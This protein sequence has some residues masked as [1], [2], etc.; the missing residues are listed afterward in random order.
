MPGLPG[1]FGGAAQHVLIPEDP[2]LFFR[3]GH[4][5]RWVSFAAAAQ[6]LVS[7]GDIPPRG[8]D[9][10]PVDSVL[11]LLRLGSEAAPSTFHGLPASRD[12]DILVIDRPPTGAPALGLLAWAAAT[13]AALVLEVE[14]E[15]GAMTVAWARPTLVAG[16]TSDLAAL[17]TALLGWGDAARLRRRRA[18]LGRLRA[19]V[20][21]E[22]DGELGSPWGGIDLP[23]VMPGP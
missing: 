5:W 14:P 12:R 19:I 23:T 17:G 13:G 20:R 4:D 18:P 16:S 21:F 2:F 9:V 10:D 11:A 7:R 22:G 8:W 1:G 6:R 3:A 15:R